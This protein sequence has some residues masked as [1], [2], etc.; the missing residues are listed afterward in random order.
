MTVGVV[1]A[2]FYSGILAAAV[3]TVVVFRGVQLLGPTRI[4]NLQFLVPAMAVTLAALFL[5]ER[6][7]PVQVAGGAVV[8][9][10]ILV[11]RG[12]RGVLRRVRPAA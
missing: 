7:Q 9:L 6:I 4:A 5:G 11:A 8:V 2:V 12:G 3:A 1:G 10:G